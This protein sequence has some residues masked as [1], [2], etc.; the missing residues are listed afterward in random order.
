MGGTSPA[1][2]GYAMP[3]ER[4]AAVVA[5]TDASSAVW[6]SGVR[7]GP[8]WLATRVASVGAPA[9]VASPV[10]TRAPPISHRPPTVPLA[11]VPPEVPPP[12]PCVTH[13]RRV[14]AGADTES[15]VRR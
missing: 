12:L 2:V 6:V 15:K 10:S 14:P 7:P 13:V 9:L 4:V 3:I 1:W 11:Y 5:V 8:S